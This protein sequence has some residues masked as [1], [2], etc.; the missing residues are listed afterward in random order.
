M[1][2]RIACNGQV[3]HPRSEIPRFS[4][5]AAEKRTDTAVVTRTTRWRRSHLTSSEAYVMFCAHSLVQT[6]DSGFERQDRG[7]F[8]L[9]V[10]VACEG[11]A[12]HPRGPTALES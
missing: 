6:E 12:C 5:S 11:T 3:L 10:D 2:E 7:L 1:R 4:S 9:L 8:S